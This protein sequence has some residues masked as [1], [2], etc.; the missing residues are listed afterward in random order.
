MGRL[1]VTC[2]L[3]CRLRPRW[4]TLNGS[5]RMTAARQRSLR[6]RLKPGDRITDGSVYAGISPDTN[7][8]M[9]ATPAD[10]PLIMKWKQAM[11]FAARLEAHGHRDWHVPTKSELNVLFQNRAAIGGFDMSRSTPAGWYWSSSHS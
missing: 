6:L 3:P 10:A 5:I 9:Y 7:K 11:E 4:H 1:P 8:P 2:R